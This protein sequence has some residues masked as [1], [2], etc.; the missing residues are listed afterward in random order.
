[1][2]DPCIHRMDFPKGLI[3]GAIFSGV[4]FF[5]WACYFLRWQQ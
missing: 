4:W 2:S 3:V 5:L 1:M